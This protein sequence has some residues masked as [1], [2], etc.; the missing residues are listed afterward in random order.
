MK[1]KTFDMLL[2]AGGM[3]LCVV[4]IVAGS[5]LTWG[6]SFISSSVHNQLAEQQIFFPPA[7]SAALASPLIKPYLTPY[8]GE[9]LLDGAQ[10]EVYA[11]HFIAVHLGE[12]GGGKTY[13][14]VSALSLAAP[15]N[16]VL[17]AEVQLLF[18][19]TTLRGLLLTSYAFWQMGQ[20]AGDAALA[21]FILA[22]IM[23]V[24]T[25][26]GLLHYRKVPEVAEL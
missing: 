14:Q 4:L 26:L 6:A 7:G 3:M 11:D 5:L 17:A 18:R 9:Q 19:G 12:I 15:K 23:L 10:A 21:A 2:S 13:A 8:A 22:G 24:L 16:A 25:V 20:I 1:R